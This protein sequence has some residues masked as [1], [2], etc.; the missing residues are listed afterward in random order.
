MAG[1]ITQGQCVHDAEAKLKSS[2]LS[3]DK[4][5]FIMGKIEAW[6]ATWSA[7]APTK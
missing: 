7:D 3:E 2:G 5:A 6:L 1:A 4:Q